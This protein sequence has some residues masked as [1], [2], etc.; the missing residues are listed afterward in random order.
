MLSYAYVYFEQLFSYRKQ[1]NSCGRPAILFSVVT[2]SYSEQRRDA[3][4]HVIQDGV[5]CP[6]FAIRQKEGGHLG[7]FSDCQNQPAEHATPKRS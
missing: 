2:S 4:A 1:I 7:K 6:R 5:W 3:Q